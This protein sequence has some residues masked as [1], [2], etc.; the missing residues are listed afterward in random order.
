[1][2]LRKS[3]EV[4]GYAYEGDTF[5]TECIEDKEKEECHPIFLGD[6]WDY[7]PSCFCGELIDVNVIG[8]ED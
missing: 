8:S 5:C 6:E 3:Y 4:T 7:Q 2:Y 1:M